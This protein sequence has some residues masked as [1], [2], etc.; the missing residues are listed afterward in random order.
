MRGGFDPTFIYELVYTAKNPRISGLGFAATRDFVDFLRNAG[1]DENPVAGT[2]RA[3]VMFGVSRSADYARQFLHLGFNESEEGRVVFDGVNPHVLPA[4]SAVNVRFWTP[5]P[6]FQDAPHRPGSDFPF[7]YRTLF[8]SVSGD[9]GGL[10]GRCTKSRS[11]PKVIETFSSAEYWQSRASLTTTDPRGKRDVGLPENVRFYL[12]SSS[13]HIPAAPFQ[14]PGIC[15][16]P[17]NT[18]DYRPGLRALVVALE[19]WVLEGASTEERRPA[20]P[21]RHPGETR[22]ASM[23]RRTWHHVRWNL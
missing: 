17:L 5:M 20:A 14:P 23:A 13:Q 9:V 11:C 1:P 6:P 2:T 15:Q 19:E 10:F 21:R 3:A 16:H 8:D 12:F 22:A 7:T 4:R 18:N